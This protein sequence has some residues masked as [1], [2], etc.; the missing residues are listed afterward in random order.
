VG[1]VGCELVD[2]AEE[3]VARE[4]SNFEFGK[5]FFGTVHALLVS[6]PLKSFDFERAPFPALGFGFGLALALAE[7]LGFLGV[8]KEVTLHR[9]ECR[10]TCLWG[11]GHFVYLMFD[12]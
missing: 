5:D 3:V 6:F 9:F 1:H 7:G 12:Y 8:S 4:L 11:R 2:A 10:L